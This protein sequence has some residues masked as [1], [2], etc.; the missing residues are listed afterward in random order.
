MLGPVLPMR[1][2]QAQPK[3]DML[4]SRTL[5][6]MLAILLRILLVAIQQVQDT[7]WLLSTRELGAYPCHL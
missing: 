1:C 4:P 7:F 5:V 3:P 6:D 2:S